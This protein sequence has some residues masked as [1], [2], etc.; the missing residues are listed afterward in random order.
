MLRTHPVGTADAHRFKLALMNE[1]LHCPT[2]NFEALCHFSRR[3][4]SLRQT[5]RNPA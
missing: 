3:E 1:P 4:K 5:L 2:G